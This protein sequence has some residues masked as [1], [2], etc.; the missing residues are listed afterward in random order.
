MSSSPEIF[1]CVPSCFQL[2][3]GVTCPQEGASRLSKEIEIPTSS[4][5]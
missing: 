3:L 1:K 2:D 5:R 4:F